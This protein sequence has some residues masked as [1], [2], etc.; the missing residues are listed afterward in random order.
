MEQAR[1]ALE[2]ALTLMSNREER[3]ALLDEYANSLALLKRWQE[4]LIYTEEALTIAP[5]DIRWQALREQITKQMKQEKPLEPNIQEPMNI[6]QDRTIRE[7][8]Q[9]KEIGKHPDELKELPFDQRVGQME[10]MVTPTNPISIFIAYAPN[11]AE[12]CANLKNQLT[13][14]IYQ[15]QVQIWYDHDISP[16]KER[17]KI[18]EE[19]L[20]ASHMILLLVSAYFLGSEYHYRQMQLALEMHRVGKKRVI[21]ILLRPSDWEKTPLGELQA[22][23]K[24]NRPVTTWRNTDEALVN[25]VKGIRLAVEE[26]QALPQ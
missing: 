16:G 14:L 12:L 7:D 21:P 15:H 3:L 1:T 6:A 10:T 24:D 11:D 26:L 17:M 4:M 8:D 13:T 9:Q 19:R 23:P 22:L 5:N 25:I 20:N 18:M 2:N